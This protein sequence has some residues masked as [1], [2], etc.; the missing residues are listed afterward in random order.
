MLN[1]TFEPAETERR[2]YALWE[3]NK[4]FSAEPTSSKKPFTIMIPP[5]NVTG[6]LHMGHALTMTLQDTLIRWKR[7]QGFDTLWQPG[8][9]HAGIATQMVVERSLATENTS[10]QA[11]GREAFTQ[12]V[13]Q[14][15][16]ESGGGITQQ[17]RRLGASLDWPRERFTMDEGLSRAVKEVFVTLYQQGLI[18]RDRRLVNW[19]PVFRSA[20]SDLEVESKDVA[21]H[22]WYIRYPVEGAGEQTITVA[23]TR[24]ETM[25]GDVAVAVHPEDERYAGLIGKSVR[26]PLTGRLIPIVADTYSDPEKGTGAVKITPAH[27]FNDFEVGRRHN[28]SMLSVL[29][30]EARVTLDEIDAD[31]VTVPG[32]ADPAFVRSLTGLPRDKARKAIVDELETLGWLEKIEPHRHQVPHAE[33]GGAVI[34]PRLTTQWYCDAGKLAGPAIEAVTSG[35]INFIPKQWENTFFAWMRDIQPWCISRQLWW[36][37]RIPAWYGPDGEVFVAHD[38]ETAHA[39]ATKHYGIE[40]ELTQDEDVLDTWFSSGLWPFSTLGWPDQTPELARYYPTDVLVTGFD[41]IFFWVA[42]MIMMGQHFMKDV[43]FRDVFIHGLVRDEHGQKMSKSKGNGIDPLELIDA[44]G[45][46][47]MRFTICSLTGIGRDVKLGRKKVED[48]RAFVTKLWN[49]ARFCEMNGVKAVEGFDPHSVQSAVGKWII[50]E[51]SQ[52]VSEATQALQVYRFDEYA[53]TCYRFVWNR[54]CDWFLELAKPI[55][56]SD[57]QQESDEIRH[58]A[59]YVLGQILRLLQPVMPFVTDDLWHAF[60]FGPEGSLIAQAWPQPIVLDGAQDALAECDQMIRLISEIRTVRSEMNVPPSQKAPVFLKDAIPE[61]VARAER[62]QEAIGRMARVTH[63]AALTGEVPKGS[64]QAVLDEATLII[65][66]EGLI[67]IS[68][69]QERLKK[70]LAKAED[71]IGKTEKKLANENFVTRAKPEIVQEMRERLTAQQGECTRLKAA[72][73]RIA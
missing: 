37:H 21:G 18:Y 63:V 3:N 50:T 72:L 65:P 31:L 53:L 19:D 4:V 66:L 71:E 15:K 57:N 32:L 10:R 33:R 69:E 8:T 55:F 64:A 49:A 42:R 13:W 28:L 70:E 45:A 2:L 12:R 73:L 1:K 58:V 35:K 48:Y 61:T 54:F 52:A 22:L 7:M 5:P 20:I 60:G 29:D 26:L 25:L 6:T 23:T 9:D 47:A 38:A 59:A 14:W 11:L 34:E 44:Y 67:D 39:L 46:D 43:P 36:G 30:E 51:V 41:I 62:W 16:E 27:D 17:L 24:P 68:A 56:A 40:T